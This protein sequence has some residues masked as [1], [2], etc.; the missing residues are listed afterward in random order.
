[1]RTYQIFRYPLWATLYCLIYI[2]LSADEDLADFDFANPKEIDWNYDTEQIADQTHNTAGQSYIKSSET[3][4][5]PEEEENQ[6]YPFDWRENILKN[7]L[8]K[9]LTNAALR[10]KFVEVMPILRV[11]SSQ[12]RL[13]LSALISAQISAKG[14]NGLKLQQVQMMFGNDEKLLLP[15]VFDI[16]NLVRNSARK[17]LGFELDVP[18]HKP[19]E[20]HITIDRRIDD[21]YNV[22]LA[23]F[24]NN[25]NSESALDDFFSETGE[26]M[27]DP[28]SINEELQEAANKRA[29]SPI[30]TKNISSTIA[31]P[32]RT[33]REVAAP[34]FVHK[35]VRSMPLSID[36]DNNSPDGPENNIKLNTSGF[37]SSKDLSSDPFPGSTTTMETFLP[38]NENKQVTGSQ[39]PST[40]TYQEVEDLAFASL[41]GTAV[42]LQVATETP[43][44]ALDELLPSPEELIA[45]PRY[46]ISSNKMPSGRPKPPTVKR[47]RV[48][49]SRMRSKIAAQN[50]IGRGGNGVAPPKKCERFTSS[51]CIR[52][53]DYPLD[54]IMGS[55]RRHKNAMTALWADYHEKSAQLDITDDFDDYSIRRREDDAT[56]GGMCQSIVRYARPQKAR[57][58][59][60]EWKYIVN[61]GQHTQTL[62][63][64][65]CTTPQESCSYLARSYRSHC[66]QVYN[67]HRL[68]SWDKTRGLHV[69]I[70]KVPTCCSCQVDGF[71]QQFPPL[72]GSKVKDFTPAV[73]AEVYSTINEELDY[74]DDQDEDVINYRFNN[75]FKGKHK[76]HDT[77]YDNNEVLLASQSVRAKL[78]SPNPTL[79]SYLSPPSGEEEY[80]IFD[81]KKQKHHHQ[82]FGS[83]SS[84]SSVSAAKNAIRNSVRRRPYTSLGTANVYN[85][86]RVDLDFSPSE[87]HPEKEV[88]LSG[89]S[90]ANPNKRVPQ[91]RQRIH[92]VPHTATVSNL[93][94]KAE[95]AGP[96][97]STFASSFPMEVGITTPATTT[98]ARGVIGNRGSIATY[99]YQTSAPGSGSNRAS[100]TQ[101][102]NSKI[103]SS[104]YR[105][106]QFASNSG[107]KQKTR[108]RSATATTLPAP[109]A[110]AEPS[111]IEHSNQ[112]SV[113]KHKQSPPAQSSRAPPYHVN[114]VYRPEYD[115]KNVGN[116]IEI[117]LTDSQNTVQAS[118]GPGPKRI[119]Y[120]YHPIIDFFQNH[121]YSAAEAIDE[122]I[123]DKSEE[124]AD[125][126]G[127][128]FPHTITKYQ[129]S[130]QS[131]DISSYQPHERRIGFGAMSGSEKSGIV[132]RDRAGSSVERINNSNTDDN[133]WHPVVVKTIGLP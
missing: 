118:S 129:T 45:G 64:E 5:N 105:N 111:P 93:F 116:D 30:K 74:N 22:E 67:Y 4:V 94:T 59:S 16:A 79:G 114:S 89:G 133:T 84:D 31:S 102:N 91:K 8:S 90:L 101:A 44:A 128:I 73:G 119:N 109:A 56:G 68:L 35:L 41:N 34:E 99:P 12:Q 62:R 71:R 69:D 88:N 61:T 2:V 20:Q 19:N 121:K 97:I 36:E 96:T 46:R 87:L 132:L 113:F 42:N 131:K 65:K 3:I 85:E 23:E 95:K 1:M 18:T 60:G 92:S 106:R 26:E 25:T 78:L 107:K 110:A 82:H 80:E 43:I 51:M 7:A 66:A 14:N 130:D 100:Q 28:Q 9:A 57:S 103:T 29:A 72:S 32:N 49:V 81:Y 37:F 15:I 39:L 21:L 38:I 108:F 122:T 24:D 117:S 53:E 120:S 47:K 98:D 55:I 27:L 48:Q 125:R 124:V 17:Y 115:A 104:V 77:G 112:W 83:S 86:A 50:S 40:Q 54:Q 76:K 11:L 75:G 123:S 70:F 63:L 13:A 58:A 52:T 10:Q 6:I 33:K 126:N 127:Q